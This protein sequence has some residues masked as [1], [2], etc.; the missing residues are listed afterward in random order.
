MTRPDPVFS[1]LSFVKS[2]NCQLIFQFFCFVFTAF[3]V[4]KTLLGLFFCFDIVAYTRVTRQSCV[5]IGTHSL[6]MRKTKIKNLK[7]GE[8][9]FPLAQILQFLLGFLM[10]F[11]D[12]ALINVF[13]FGFGIKLYK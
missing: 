4:L 3:L 10:E 11:D 6:S 5:P 13:K 7:I 12:Q 9:K 8:K 1:V 2:E